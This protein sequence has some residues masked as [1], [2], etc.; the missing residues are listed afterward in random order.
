MQSPETKGQTKPA[1]GNH[2]SS[3]GKGG[4]GGA[5]VVGEHVR[6]ETGFRVCD[7]LA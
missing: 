1:R 7:M 3:L 5:V 6:G 2:I 4:R